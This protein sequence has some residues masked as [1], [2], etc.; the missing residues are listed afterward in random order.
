[1][2]FHSL[3]DIYYS[4]YIFKRLELCSDFKVISPGACPVCIHGPKYAN[5]SL[6]T[7][8]SASKFVLKCTKIAQKNPE[9]KP[10]VALTD[11]A[12]HP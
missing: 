5:S 6:L 3:C 10:C 4:F 9:R 8:I 11:S 7:N 1:M 2:T 12:W